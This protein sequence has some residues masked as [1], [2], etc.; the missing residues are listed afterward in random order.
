MKTSEQ[1]IL[2]IS[3]IPLSKREKTVFQLIIE[4]QT[5]QQIADTLFISIHT[6]NFHRKN[7]RSKLNVNSIGEM[8]RYAYQYQVV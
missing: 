7:I 6:V 8:I 5:S 3:N 2:P 4:G 1:L